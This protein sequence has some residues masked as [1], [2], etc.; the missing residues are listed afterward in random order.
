MWRLNV[1]SGRLN[2]TDRRRRDGH[3]GEHGRGHDCGHGRSGERGPQWPAIPPNQEFSGT[4]TLT[5]VTN[6]QGNTGSGG[7]LSDTDTVAITIN[8][9]DDP[10]VNQLPANPQVG[11]EDEPLVMSAATGNA[12]SIVDVDAG[13]QPAQ[14]SLSLPA[15]TVGALTLAST[16]GLTFTQ[17]DG[18]AD[19][20]MTFTGTIAAINAALAAGLT[21]TVPP[22]TIVSDTL[23]IS[24]TSQ[25]QTDT[26]VLGIEVIP[27][28][29]PRAINDPLSILE[30]AA[31]TVINVL[32]ND[33]PNDNSQA[34][35]LSFTQ[36]AN[37]VVTRNENGTPAIP[38]DDTLSYRPNGN[39]AGTDTFTYTINDTSGLGDDS[40]AT[41]V[42]TVQ[43]VNDAP[44]LTVPGARTI[45][46]DNPLSFGAGA[47][48]VSDVDAGT[49]QYQSDARS[50]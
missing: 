6:D 44:Q 24:T 35:L 32:S 5:I 45:A 31:A 13:N 34:T 28:V 14:V 16:T 41:V 46:E 48:T 47:I 18:T 22:L 40:T 50:E 15:A 49:R 9:V 2:V 25:G 33:R 42:V 37:G 17:G 3:R 30:D 10:P 8:A 26:D 43:A 4:D 38:R 21:Y 23:T 7:A 12:L 11:I 39:F 20:S 29:R 19:T 1:A 36:P 27:A